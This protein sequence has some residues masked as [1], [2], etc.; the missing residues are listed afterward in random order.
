MKFSDFSNRPMGVIL[1]CVV[2][3][4]AIE[5][6]RRRTGIISSISRRGVIV[7]RKKGGGTESVQFHLIDKIVK[8]V[9]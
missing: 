8:E 9:E 1:G 2:Q 7:R 4:L 5:T 6:M 3:Y